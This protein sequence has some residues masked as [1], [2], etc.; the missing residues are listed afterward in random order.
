MYSDLGNKSQVYE[1]TLD[2][3][4]IHQHGAS[5]KYFQLLKRFIARLGFI[6][7]LRM[8]IGPKMPIITIINWKKTEFQVP[9][10]M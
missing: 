6:L 9:C 10:W 8:V 1:L 4:E 7:S 2:L 5:I 3:G